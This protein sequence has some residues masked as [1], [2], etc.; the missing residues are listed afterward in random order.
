MHPA[1]TILLKLPVG[2]DSRPCLLKYDVAQINPEVENITLC[3]T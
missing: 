3:K 1:G 2:G